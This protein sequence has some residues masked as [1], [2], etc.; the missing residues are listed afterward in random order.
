M[1][2]PAI[3]VVLL[4]LALLPG[5][6][7][8]WT[9]FFEAMPVAGYALPG[10]ANAPYSERAALTRAAADGVVPSVAASLGLA[11]KMSPVAIGPCGW[12]LTTQPAMR[13]DVASDRNAA[14][15]LAAALGYVFRQSAVL[16]A[17]FDDT[18][19]ETT[20]G[21]VSLPPGPADPMLTHRFYLHAAATDSILEGGYSSVPEGLLFLGLGKT[22]PERFVAGLRRAA[23]TFGEPGM[24]FVRSG[25]AKAMLVA[26]NWDVDS[27]GG[28]YRGRFPQSTVALLD[29]ATQR[30]QALIDRLAERFRWRP[31][32]AARDVEPQ[33]TSPGP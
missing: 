3:A 32:P 33:A 5:P 22:D 23:E 9:L 30:N 16:V 17:D 26:N 8:A 1:R 24:R 2:R 13:A 14:I 10:L 4:F 12:R 28:A 18:A 21:V 6:A 29:Q 7:W 27:E 19:G 11:G 15:H 20:Y 31:A 25:K